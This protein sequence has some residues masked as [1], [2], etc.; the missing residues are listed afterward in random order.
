MFNTKTDWLFNDHQKCIHSRYFKIIQCL[1]NGDGDTASSSNQGAVPQR[2]TSVWGFGSQTFIGT[3][4]TR[5][6]NITTKTKLKFSKGSSPN[7]L[8][9][10]NGFYYGSKTCAGFFPSTAM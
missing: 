9:T 7:L 4:L 3:V 1:L 2:V 6:G 8:P 5:E 10:D